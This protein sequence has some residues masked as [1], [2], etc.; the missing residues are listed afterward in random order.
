MTPFLLQSSIF[1]MQDFSEKHKFLRKKG[2]RYTMSCRRRYL[3]IFN[4]IIS[5]IQLPRIPAWYPKK[6]KDCLTLSFARINPAAS[7]FV[8]FV[9]NIAPLH[10]KENHRCQ[11]H[12]HYRLNTV[13]YHLCFYHLLRVETVMCPLFPL[14][15]EF[16]YFFF[17]FLLLV[18]LY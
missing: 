3:Y 2:H 18:F 14:R 4:A 7:S 15:F 8:F 9:I 11:I 12:R 1:N 13:Q 6:L 5:A 17:S 10:Q 16:D